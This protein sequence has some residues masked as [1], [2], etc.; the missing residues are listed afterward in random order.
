MNH[1]RLITLAAMSALGLT[2]LTTGCGRTLS[3]TE[4]THVRRDGTVS[5]REKTVTEN[6]DGTVTKTETRKN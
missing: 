6:P 3:K 5:T 1:T 2:L 4:E